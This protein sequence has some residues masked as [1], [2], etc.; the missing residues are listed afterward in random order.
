M[1]KIFVFGNP[2]VEE[3]SIA[4]SVAEELR[5]KKEF[6]SFKFE[7]IDS[8]NDLGKIPK[9]LV[10]LDCAEGIKKIGIIRDLKKFVATQKV[11]LHDFDLGTE[12]LLLEKIGKLK[13]KKICIVA[14]PRGLLLEEAVKG[15]SS[16]L[17]KSA[18]HRKCTGRKP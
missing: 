18:L 4:L 8:I 3:D 17:L 14:V 10:I 16:L 2:V 5:K 13:E 15:V 9:E 7:E 6:K 12:L 1:K 11:S